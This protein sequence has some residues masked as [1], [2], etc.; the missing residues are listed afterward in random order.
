MHVTRLRKANNTHPG[1]VFSDISNVFAFV[2]CEYVCPCS[3]TIDSHRDQDCYSRCDWCFDK[4]KDNS[5]LS[6]HILADT[7]SLSK[8]LNA[9]RF[10]KYKVTLLQNLKL[11]A[12]DQTKAFDYVC[13]KC[14]NNCVYRD[15]MFY[16]PVTEE[17]MFRF[18]KDFIDKC[19]QTGETKTFTVYDMLFGFDQNGNYINYSPTEAFKM[20]G[21]DPDSKILDNQSVYYGSLG[22]VQNEDKH[23]SSLEED[24]WL[25]SEIEALVVGMKK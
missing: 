17:V 19:K 4:L 8:F 9:D 11:D 16:H 25:P 20:L 10:F 15:P 7:F 3:K 24:C 14:I 13:A 18:S 23:I 5:C 6:S 1:R 21:N 2:S 12:I 22:E